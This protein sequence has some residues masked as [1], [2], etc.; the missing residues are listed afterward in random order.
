MVPLIQ[1]SSNSCVGACVHVPTRS[2]YR[3]NLGMSHQSVCPICC[4][5]CVRCC[6]P[7]LHS[8]KYPL[9]KYQSPMKASNMLSEFGHSYTCTRTLDKI[10][11]RICCLKIW[12][13]LRSKAL[14]CTT[15]TVQAR[16]GWK[17]VEITCEQSN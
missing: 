14:S 11:L 15:S 3:C 10:Q 17:D 7:H 6:C 5:S 2:L 9:A 12:L 4:Q 16:G 13:Y 1:L 8:D